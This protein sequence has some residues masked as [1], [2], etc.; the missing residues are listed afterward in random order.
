MIHQSSATLDLATAL[1]DGVKI[2]ATTI[3]KKFGIANPRRHVHYLRQSG[4]PIV[5]KPLTRTIKK[6]RFQIVEYSIP[7]V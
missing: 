2:T 5:S 6:R 4:V 3:T 7:T 1:Y